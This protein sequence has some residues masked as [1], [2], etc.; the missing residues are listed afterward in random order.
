MSE[1]ICL[2]PFTWGGKVTSE[3]LTEIKNYISQEGQDRHIYPHKMDQNH[4]EAQFWPFG[5]VGPNS[6][7]VE[8]QELNSSETS[9]DN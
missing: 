3:T 6:V 1:A 4:F 7:I 9:C 2:N 8:K 5:P